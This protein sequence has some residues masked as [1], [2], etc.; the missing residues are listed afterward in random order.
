MLYNP[1]IGVEYVF[2]SYKASILSWTSFHFTLSLIYLLT[3]GDISSRLISLSLTSISIFK[4]APH[5]TSILTLPLITLTSFFITVANAL[6]LETRQTRV[7]QET[8]IV[9]EG[10]NIWQEHSLE[11]SIGVGTCPLSASHHSSRG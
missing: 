1:A 11:I 5:E 2:S 3:C 9:D 10:Q 6:P 7:A 8:S 4:M